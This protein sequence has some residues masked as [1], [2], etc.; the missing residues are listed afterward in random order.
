MCYGVSYKC[1]VSCINTDLN[2]TKL[3]EGI[4]SGDGYG[5]GCTISCAEGIRDASWGTTH[6]IS[7]E[8]PINTGWIGVAC[9]IIVLIFAGIFFYMRY[10]AKEKKP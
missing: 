7:A 2:T 8:A 3:G 10:Y 9:L 6:A 4:I 5:S 1:A